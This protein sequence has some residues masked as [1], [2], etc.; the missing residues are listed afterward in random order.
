MIF[1]HLLGS[2][3]VNYKGFRAGGGKNLTGA[4]AGNSNGTGTITNT[5]YRWESPVTN[6]ANLTGGA[7]GEGI[8]G[9]PAYYFD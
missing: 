2:I 7:K 4:T 9:T 6:A 8:A 3:D 5:D 1:L